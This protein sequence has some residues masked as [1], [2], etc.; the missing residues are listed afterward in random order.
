MKPSRPSEEEKEA[1]K[2]KLIKSLEWDVEFY[3]KKLNESKIH[4]DLLLESN[5][6]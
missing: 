5:N 2:Q 4:L 1:T 3:T 6:N